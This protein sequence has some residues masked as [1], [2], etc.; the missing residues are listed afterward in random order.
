MYNCNCNTEEVE[1][2]RSEIQGQ[3]QVHKEFQVSLGHRRSCLQISKE[4]RKL[5]IQLIPDPPT[6]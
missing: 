1:T 5:Y 6:N 4:T 2:G 3:S